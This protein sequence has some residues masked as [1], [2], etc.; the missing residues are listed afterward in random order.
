[1][2]YVW[3]PSTWGTDGKEWIW[4]QPHLQV[5]IN[6]I[7]RTCLKK[8]KNKT[9]HSDHAFNLSSWEAEALDL[10]EFE[11]SLVYRA[12]QSCYTEKA[13]L[14]KTKPTNKQTSQAW[15]YM[16]LTPALRRK[17]Q[18]NLYLNS[19]PS[20]STQWILGQPCLI[21]INKIN[22][23]DK[24]KMS[25]LRLLVAQLPHTWQCTI[26]YVDMWFYDL[27]KINSCILST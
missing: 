8:I 15:W 1:M 16:P 25:N 6:Y 11:T 4:G 24:R 18:S 17:S 21:K 27:I 2:V 13:C 10:C 20:W 23:K 3:N 12:S 14:K 7:L 9:R 5:N 26:I 22:N 19:R